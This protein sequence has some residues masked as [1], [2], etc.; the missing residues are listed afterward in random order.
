MLTPTDRIGTQVG[1]LVLEGPE[2]ID[3][4]GPEDWA[5]C[6]WHLGRRD[7]LFVVT[8]NQEVG[9]GHV[10][11]ALTVADAL[12]RHRIRFLVDRESG[13]AADAIRARHHRSACR[14]ASASRTTSA[15]S[16]RT[17]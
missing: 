15:T 7:V 14:P 4:D 10:H 5:L 8:G 16:V 17:S 11:N 3:I 2:A 1:V 6:E 9:L 12:T 13:M